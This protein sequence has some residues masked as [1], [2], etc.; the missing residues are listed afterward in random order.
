MMFPLPT[1]H[2][3]RP[4]LEHL[5]GRQHSSHR[6]CY[7]RPGTWF[8]VRENISTGHGRFLYSLLFLR[9]CLVQTRTRSPIVSTAKSWVYPSSSPF[10]TVGSAGTLLPLSSPCWHLTALSSLLLSRTAALLGYARSW[11]CTASRTDANAS[12]RSNV[13]LFQ[14]HN[15]ALWVGWPLFGFL[16]CG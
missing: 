9:G 15:W 10:F 6:P 7:R 5:H 12:D 14:L 2:L 3:L 16:L 8:A 11:Y 13:W 4:R 1:P